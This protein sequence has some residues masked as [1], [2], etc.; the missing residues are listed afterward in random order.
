MVIRIRHKIKLVSTALILL[1]TV[2]C[3]PQQPN[4]KLG[5]VLPLTGSFSI[6]GQQALKGAQLAVDQ[7]N[8]QG[9][10]LNRQLELVI[11]DN[12]TDPAKTVKYSRELVQ[13]NQVFALFGPVSSAARYAM[14]EVAET[15]YT[16]LFYGIDYE[17]RHYSRYLICYST[18]PEHYIEPIVPYLIENIGK[19]FYIFG[20]DYIWPHRMAKSIVKSVSTHQGNVTDIEFTPFGIK[21]FTPVFERIKESG[22]ETLMLILPGAD[23]FTFLSQMKSFDFGRDVQVVAF[24]ADETYLSNLDNDSLEGILT[25]LHFFSSNDDPILQKFVNDYKAHHGTESVVTY[26]SKAHY[27]LIYLLQAAIEQAG[28]VDKEAV[29]NQLPGL[30]LYEKDLAIKLR[31]DHHFELPM[32]LGQFAAGQLNVIERLGI[33]KPEDQR[34][35]GNE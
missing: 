20:Y 14:A 19:N 11:R 5:V 4:I 28:V 29:I 15:F 10:V 1:F 23:G 35:V 27:D 16:P 2:S 6:Y 26:S 9:G 24:A 21:D 7:I 25:A 30:T 33:I 31:D 13:Q 18:I 17:G 8:A 34:S 3:L 12:Q 32:Y 22:A